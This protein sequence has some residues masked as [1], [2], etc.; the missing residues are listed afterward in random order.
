MEER[1]EG[2]RDSPDL[3][4]SF[5]NLSGLGVWSFE[6]TIRLNPNGKE[7]TLSERH[8]VGKA[9]VC[10]RCVVCFPKRDWKP[11]YILKGKDRTEAEEIK[12]SWQEYTGEL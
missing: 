5:W 4:S 10:N 3:H 8:H 12:N 1:E 6:Q 11:G 9:V 7:R 2:K